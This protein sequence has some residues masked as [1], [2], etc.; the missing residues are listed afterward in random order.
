MEN[1]FYT[2]TALNNQT[3]LGRDNT[4]FNI[5]LDRDIGASGATGARVIIPDGNYDLPLITSAIVSNALSAVRSTYGYT[6]TTGYTGNTGYFYF[7]IDQDP[8]TLKLTFTS[9]HE[10]N[11]EFPVTTSNF[12]K[13]GLGYNLGFYNTNDNISTA[14]APYTLAAVT[15]PD[16]KQDY[17]VYIVINDWYQVQHQ[18]ADQTKLSAFLKVPITTPKFTVQYD[19]VQLDTVTKEYFFPQ[20][21]NIHKLEISIVD[22]YG[23]VLNMQ[24]GSFSM[25]LAI[26]EILQSNIYEKMLQI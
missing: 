7:A 24:G 21:Q 23:T 11:L 17:Y 26:S 16:L 15:R 25:S 5:T 4:S 2:F 20:P 14:V 13:N 8:R 1:S 9:N 12:T 22:N 10:F 18:Y 19:N 3:G 6:G